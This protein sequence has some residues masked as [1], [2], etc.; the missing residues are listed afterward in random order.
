MTI[1][2]TNGTTSSNNGTSSSNNG[3]NSSV[4]SIIGYFNYLASLNHTE[5]PTSYSNYST[6][7]CLCETIYATFDNSPNLKI[8]WNQLQ[9]IFLGK[10]LYAPNTQPYNDLVKKINSTFALIDELI[11]VLT[12]ADVLI[13]DVENLK[14]LITVISTQIFQN[15]INT[16]QIFSIIE[17]LQSY[18]PVLLVVRSLLGCFEWNKFEGYATEAELVDVGMDM[19]NEGTFW[20][21]IIF[22]NSANSTTLPNLISYKIRMATTMTHN[23]FY[24]QDRYYTYGPNNCPTCNIDFLYGYIYLQDMIEKSIIEIKTNSTQDYGITM[25]M[26][27]YPCFVRDLFVNAIT[28]TLPLFMVLAWIY[29]VSM[30]VKDIVYEKEKRLKEFMRVMGLSNGIHWL[31]WF[32]TAFVSMIVI[33]ILLVI[34]LKY[35]KITQYS[36]FGALLV[37]FMCF[38]IATITQCF[39]I[40]VFF[41]R[42][43]LAAAVAGNTL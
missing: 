36:D 24:S 43:N 30:L 13:N 32:I 42:A 34:I 37:F 41:N 17:T 33:C 10:I 19:I 20:A 4:T 5:C 39:L 14:P 16:S 18:R 7:S 31:A 3:T 22:N 25:Q 1:P 29:T 15:L 28:R 11:N 21:A 23:T 12:Q 27:G 6:K 8:I 2:G 26:S 40:S 9:P 35:G 38:S